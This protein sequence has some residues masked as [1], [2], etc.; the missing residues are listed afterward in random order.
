MASQEST[1]EKELRL[2]RNV[3]F[4]IASASTDKKLEDLPDKFLAPLLLKLASESLP[5]RN[6]VG[7]PAFYYQYP[8]HLSVC[9]SRV[10]R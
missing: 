10:R 3:E 5:V 6:K 1:E 2:V 7:F 9:D 8:T 4:K